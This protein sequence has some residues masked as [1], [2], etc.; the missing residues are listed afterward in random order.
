MSTNYKM[1]GM[2]RKNRNN[3]KNVVASRKNRKNR[4]GSRKN[5][6]GTNN[7]PVVVGGK[8]RAS[9]RGRKGSRRAGRR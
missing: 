9:R 7:A 1:P 4:M 6:K 5:R 2:T 3:R 8:R